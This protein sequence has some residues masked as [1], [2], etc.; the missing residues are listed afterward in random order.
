VLER[1]DD[2]GTV[3]AQEWQEMLVAGE[4]PGHGQR[5]EDGHENRH[6][7]A[8][9]GAHRFRASSG[10]PKAPRV[11]SRISILD[12]SSARTTPRAV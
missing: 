12:Q 2:A 4:I 8:E 6:V 10:R 7:P 3:H 5:T 1:L 11:A 9:S